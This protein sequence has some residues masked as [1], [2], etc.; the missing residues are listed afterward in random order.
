VSR[1]GATNISEKLLT[2]FNNKKKHIGITIMNATKILFDE[3]GILYKKLVIKP[4]IEDYFVSGLDLTEA[5]FNAVGLDLEIV[6]CAEALDEL[7][8][9]VNDYGS[10]N[11]IKK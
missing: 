7:R 8:E 10:D 6:I 5:L 4:A 2:I 1:S 9:E 3:D 11:T